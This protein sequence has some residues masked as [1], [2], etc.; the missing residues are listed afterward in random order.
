[1]QGHG[2]PRPFSINLDCPNHLT[3]I[4]KAE[5]PCVPSLGFASLQ[6]ITPPAT[7]ASLYYLGRATSI[8]MGKQKDVTEIALMKKPLTFPQ[9]KGLDGAVFSLLPLSNQIVHFHSLSSTWCIGVPL[10]AGI[11]QFSST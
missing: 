7:V 1:M 10:F 5:N 4:E 11:W 8:S 9:I 3:G 6:G 2:I